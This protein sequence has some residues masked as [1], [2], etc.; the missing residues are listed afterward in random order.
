MIGHQ[1]RENLAA[2]MNA[3]GCSSHD[4]GIIPNIKCTEDS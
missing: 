1:K 4:E 3:A 2:S